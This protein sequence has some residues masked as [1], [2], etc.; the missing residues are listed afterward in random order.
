[1]SLTRS[2]QFRF[3][4][5]SFIANGD[6][7]PPQITALQVTCEHIEVPAMA[8]GSQRADTPV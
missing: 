5:N 3:S 8:H 1:M 2:I 4:S 7:P 6:R